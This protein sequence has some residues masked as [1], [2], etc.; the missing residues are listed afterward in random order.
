MNPFT[1]GSAFART[2]THTPHGALRESLISRALIRECTPT[3]KRIVDI[4]CGEA[5]VAHILARTWNCSVHGYDPSEDMRHRAAHTLHDVPHAIFQYS[6]NDVLEHVHLAPGD[7]VLCH[8]VLNWHTHAEETLSQLLSWVRAQR[9]TLSLVVGSLHGYLIDA[10]AHGQP[11]PSL[12]ERRVRSASY[13]DETLYL[14]DPS[15]VRIQI[16]RSGA[17]VLFHGGVRTLYDIAP[18]PDF[19]T[20]LLL[21]ESLAERE[22]YRSMG[23]LTHFLISYA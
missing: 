16:D 14:F 1:Q 9:G 18:D 7:L 5:R 17:R 8:A 3:P 22:P 11:L 15:E 23:D 4:G 12:T 2:V 21:E 13:P 19:D 6:I 20:F 10:C